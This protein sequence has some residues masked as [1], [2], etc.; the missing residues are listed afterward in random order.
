MHKLPQDVYEHTTTLAQE[1]FHLCLQGEV[2]Y[3]QELLQRVRTQLKRTS[4]DLP[5]FSSVDAA[6]TSAYHTPFTTK[7]IEEANAWGWLEL[8]SGV[9]KLVQDLPGTSL[10]H[11]T[12]SWRIWRAWTLDTT[13][14][15]PMQLLQA[16]RERIRASLWLGEAWARFMS[17]R[18]EHTA[19]AILRVALVELERMAAQDILQET[20]QQQYLL[21]PAAL[22]TPAYST[23]GVVNPYVCLL[24][25]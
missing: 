3:G 19:R 23:D 5:I 15:S 17:E 1:A 4:G 22:G 13:S 8:A 24:L 9:F 25:A 16:R 12:R 18:A 7:S 2:Y 21:P 6:H 10:M 11:F 20:I 14:L